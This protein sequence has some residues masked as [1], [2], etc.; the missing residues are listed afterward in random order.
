[1]AGLSRLRR[2][3]KRLHPEGIPWPGTVLY[4][5]V[6]SSNIFQRHYEVLAQDIL[7]Y[8]AEGRLLDVGT[9][10]GWLLLKLHQQCPG[11]Q[12][13][14]LDVS[15]QMAANAR[16]NMAEAGLAERVEIIEGNASQI[17]FPDGCFDIVVSTGSIHHWKEPTA[18]LNEVHRVLKDGG[19]GLMYDL[20]SDTPASV[21]K[22]IQR[23]FGSLRTMLFWLHSFEEPFYSRRDFE[24]LAGPTQFREG[25][26]RFVC[27]LCCLILEKGR[28]S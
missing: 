18:G 6:S 12:L 8:G 4:N 5:W 14:G 21:L 23:E 26:S 11:M 28:N 25:Q 22:E 20:V 10:P 19:Y 1:M 2:L 7:S 3:L 27:L 24:A 13:V 16:K 17:P 15:P 9:G